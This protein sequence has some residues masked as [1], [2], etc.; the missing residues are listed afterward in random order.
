MNFINQKTK[1]LIAADRLNGISG[2][3]AYGCVILM[4]F[5]VAMVLSLL[6]AWLCPIFLL[7]VAPVVFCLFS[8][9]KNHD[10]TLS[11]AR[12]I[13]SFFEQITKSPVENPTLSISFANNF[14]KAHAL[15]VPTPP[16]R[17]F[18]FV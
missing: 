7:L 5:V 13:K 3:A 18:R 1:E 6:A 17:Q 2:L 8:G 4:V 16:P 9:G 14:H 15:E 12:K 11:Q 10:R